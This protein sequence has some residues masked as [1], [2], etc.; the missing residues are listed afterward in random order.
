VGFEPTN[1]LRRY[2]LSREAPSTQILTSE[3]TVKST[4][5]TEDICSL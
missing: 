4:D 3:N 5:P 1:A 2:F